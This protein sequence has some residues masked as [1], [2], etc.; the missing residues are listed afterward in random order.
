MCL[1]SGIAD[2]GTDQMVKLFDV[3]WCQVGQISILAVV[4]YL[5]NWIE[6]GRV[7]R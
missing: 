3:L 5:L 7:A 1:L 2:R 4:P 6:V